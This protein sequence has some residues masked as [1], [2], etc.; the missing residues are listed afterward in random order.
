MK[1][2]NRTAVATIGVAMTA[3]LGVLGLAELA[4]SAPSDSGGGA[5]K[6]P[7]V[8]TWTVDAKPG[9]R[10]QPGGKL[11]TLFADHNV[12]LS[13]PGALV[14]P[15]GGGLEFVGPGQGTYIDRSRSCTFSTRVLVADDK[16]AYSGYVTV[17]GT[18]KVD[19][20]ERKISGPVA[21]ERVLANGDVVGTARTTFTG[22]RVGVR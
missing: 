9:P 15:N 8:G 12:I 2:S 1:M 22:Q 16:G 13:E 6:R 18:V 10:I 19:R 7:C 11:I 3:G 5:A 17:S 21:I 14:S 20:Q 4:S